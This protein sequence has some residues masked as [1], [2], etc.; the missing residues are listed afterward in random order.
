MKPLISVIVCT[1]NR[2]QLLAGILDDLCNQTLSEA[3]YEVIIVDNNSRDSTKAVVEEYVRSKPNWKGCFEPVQGLS[4]ARNHGLKESR[5]QYVA[6]TDDDCRVPSNWLMMAQQII[7]EMAP[8]VFGGPYYA[9]YN[10][11]KPDWYKDVY[12]SHDHGNQPRVL[13]AEEYLDGGNFFCRRH[14]IQGVGGFNPDLGMQGEKRFYG[15][16]VELVRKIRAR[17]PEEI[18]F[19][20]PC[21][22]VNHLVASQKMDLGHSIRERFMDGRSWLVTFEKPS[23]KTL[24]ILQL[25]LFF[26]LALARVILIVTES[27]VG[28]IR[29]DYQQYPYWK[30]Y[31]YEKCLRYFGGLGMIYEKV[32][33]IFH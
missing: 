21:L 16:E 1:F 10:T 5:G 33:S 12:G 14:L 15:E 30:N 22:K 6:Y 18:I 19:Y 32:T 24:I 11:P 23:S 9:I 29:R 8:A 3:F 17:F 7:Q 25:P 2:S 27:L 31:F 13:T 20:H 26:C 4:H 28:I